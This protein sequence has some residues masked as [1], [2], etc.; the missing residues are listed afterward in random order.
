LVQKAG[1]MDAAR[2]RLSRTTE[3]VEASSG[4]LGGKNNTRPGAPAEKMRRPE[5]SATKRGR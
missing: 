5:P 3:L 1:R 2:G 4:T